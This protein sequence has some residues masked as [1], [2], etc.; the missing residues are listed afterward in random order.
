MTVVF[1][2]LYRTLRKRD[3]H[4]NLWIRYYIFISRE[5][6][7]LYHRWNQSTRFLRECLNS[8]RLLTQHLIINLPVVLLRWL[9]GYQKYCLYLW[10]VLIKT[11]SLTSECTTSQRTLRSNKKSYLSLPTH[12]CLLYL[13]EWSPVLFTTLCAP[14]NAYHKQNNSRY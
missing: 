9:W 7:F 12:I 8:G 4:L 3:T 2:F 14:T 5:W 1:F 10:K 11:K 6:Q 13:V